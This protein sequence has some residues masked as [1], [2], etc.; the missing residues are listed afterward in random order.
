MKPVFS[1]ELYI[2]FLLIFYAEW[3]IYVYMYIHKGNKDPY[4]VL[5]IVLNTCKVFT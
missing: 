2:V 5:E 4:F 1:A 3:G